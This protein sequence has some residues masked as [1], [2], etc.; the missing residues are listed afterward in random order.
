MS[1]S[2]LGPSP[3]NEILSKYDSAKAELGSARTELRNQILKT[4]ADL[5]LCALTF[6]LITKLTDNQFIGFGLAIGVTA[7]IIRESYVFDDL[8]TAIE[9]HSECSRRVKALTGVLNYMGIAVR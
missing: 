2:K 9:E 3:L 7:G 6:V 4:G 8:P 5:A 1:E